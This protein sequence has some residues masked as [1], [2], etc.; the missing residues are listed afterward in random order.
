M[1]YAVWIYME[2]P[3]YLKGSASRFGGLK[4]EPIDGSK[5]TSDA[6]HKMRIVQI[7]VGGEA[8]EG[9]LRDM[10]NACSTTSIRLAF[11]LSI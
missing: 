4:P 5:K 1:V 7:F 9:R 8:D 2:G 11:A 10:L 3:K 6:D